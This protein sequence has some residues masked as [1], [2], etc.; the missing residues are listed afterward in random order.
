VAP[1]RQRRIL[2]TK[3]SRRILEEIQRSEGIRIASE[4]IEI[5]RFPDTGLQRSSIDHSSLDNS[6]FDHSPF[7]HK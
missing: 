5:A 1:A 7:E 6:S 4:S 3:I 2:R